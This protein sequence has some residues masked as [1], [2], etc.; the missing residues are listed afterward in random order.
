MIR[1]AAARGEM[2]EGEDVGGGGT[3]GGQLVYVCLYDMR[4]SAG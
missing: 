4:R 2:E 1:L 3:G